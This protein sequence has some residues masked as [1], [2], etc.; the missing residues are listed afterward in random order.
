MRKYKEHAALAVSVALFMNGHMAAHRM[1][2]GTLH[3]PARRSRQSARVIS[4]QT[5]TTGS[6]EIIFVIPT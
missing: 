6:A 2:R 1:R 3:L 4:T 5:H